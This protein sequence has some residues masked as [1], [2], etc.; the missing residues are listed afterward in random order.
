[1]IYDSVLKRLE[2]IVEYLKSRKTR[3]YYHALKKKTINERLVYAARPRC[4]CGASM[5]YD[6][7]GGPFGYW[8]CSDILL[9]KA[10][11]EVLHTP[12]LPFTFYEIKSEKQPSVYGATTRER[13]VN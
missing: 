3:E 1:M 2:K 5:A 4:L 8:D 11:V 10:K 7:A 9:D 6:P 12:K 13:I